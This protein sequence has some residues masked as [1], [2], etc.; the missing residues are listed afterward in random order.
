MSNPRFCTRCNIEV[1]DEPGEHLC[2]DL[3]KRYAR[4]ERQVAAVILI[5]DGEMDDEGAIYPDKFKGA[6]EEIVKVL[7]NLG[8]E[9]DI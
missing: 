9:D 5:L 7:A 8:V 1:F 2:A 6:A 4:R 3:A